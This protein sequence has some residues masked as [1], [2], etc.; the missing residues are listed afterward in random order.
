MA[1]Q[2]PRTRTLSRSRGATS[3]ILLVLLGA[4]GA[5]APFVGPYFNFTYTPDKT[6]HWTAARGWF[7]V[8]PGSV[9]FVAGLLL[10]VGRSRGLTLIGAWLGILAGAWF[11]IGPPLSSELTLGSLGVPVGTSSGQRAGETLGLFTGLGAV[12][13]F[14]AAA[15][16]GRLSVVTVRDQRLAERREAERAEAEELA[17][18]EQAEREH[19]ERNRWSPETRDE[20]DRRAAAWASG[21]QPY[22]QHA[23]P[24]G[25]G[26]QPGYTQQLP[27]QQ[28]DYPEQQ[29]QDPSQEGQQQGYHSAP[30]YREGEQTEQYS[31]PGY[32]RH[33]ADVRSQ[34]DQATESGDR[35]SGA[36]ALGQHGAPEPPPAAPA[37][38]STSERPR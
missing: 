33:D 17:A 14:L 21:D 5:I 19:A 2:T 23:Y 11:V 30:G 34:D 8:L 25:A 37:T 31:S 9:A 20:Q 15:A 12:I 1:E 18:R 7:Q 38:D 10:L 3:G 6:W 4:W 26:D 32:G 22:D 27:P 36:S 16:F 13:I 24:G 29:Y 35:A 28:G